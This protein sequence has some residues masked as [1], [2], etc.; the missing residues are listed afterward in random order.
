MNNNRAVR[1]P[2]SDDLLQQIHAR[3]QEDGLRIT[4][5]TR[6]LWKAWIDR[7]FEIGAVRVAGNGRQREGT[8]E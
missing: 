6:F 8:S 5:V 2:V 1:I 3:A 4:Q 7:E